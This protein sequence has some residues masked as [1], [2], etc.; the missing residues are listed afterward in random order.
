M[1]LKRVYIFLPLAV[2]AVILGFA[3]AK[4]NAPPSDVVRF[5][6]PTRPAPQV[7][8]AGFD[9]P[10]VNIAAYRGRPVLINFWGS[11]C[12]P[13][14]LEH[15]ILMQMKAAGVEIV[16]VLYRDPDEDLA[17][18]ILQRDGNPFAA[19]ANDPEG[20]AFVQFGAAG[21]PESF[22]IDASGVIIKS[23]RGD[24]KAED[25]QAFIAAYE[26]AKVKSAAA[27]AS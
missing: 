25:A 16:G 27:P 17:R 19:L 6:S 11:Y 23:K 26:A 21:V 18:E 20:D 14:K 7:E 12:A 4:L 24:I 8:I 1:S 22:L 9:G 15:P 2:L 10:A 5:E 13:C 3:L